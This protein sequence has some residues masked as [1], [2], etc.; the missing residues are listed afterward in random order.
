M[1]A[2]TIVEPA[3]ATLRRLASL[4]KRVALLPRCLGL[5][6]VELAAPSETAR[7]VYLGEGEG[8]A[9]VRA[10]LAQGQPASRIAQVPL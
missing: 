7:I 4:A 3:N 6:S 8:L 10:V 2:L 9:F 1:T 5:T